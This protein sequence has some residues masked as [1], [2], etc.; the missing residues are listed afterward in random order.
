MNIAQLIS[1]SIQHSLSSFDHL[2]RWRWIVLKFKFA[3]RRLLLAIHDWPIEYRIGNLV[4]ALP[5]SHKLPIDDAATPG[6]SDNLG[7][8]AHWVCSQKGNL[9][10]IDIG[11]NVGD[12]IAVV[13][14]N[15]HFPILA[16]EG[17][18]EFYRFLTMNM[19]TVPDIWTYH[20]L[21]SDTPHSAPGV[22]LPNYGGSKQVAIRADAHDTLRF[23]TLVEVLEEFPQF[24]NSG[25]I[26]IDTDGFDCKILR[27]AL[28][29]LTIARPVVFFEYDPYHL[30]EQG[31]DGISIFEAL[32]GI[33]YEGLLVFEGNG[34][35]M[36]SLELREKVLVEELHCYFLGRQSKKYANLCAFHSNDK[37]LFEYCRSEELR[38]AASIRS[39]DTHHQ[40]GRPV[41]PSDKY[42]FIPS[43]K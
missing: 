39:A 26:K 8:I 11:A 6:R 17:D 22:L 28:P 3:L 20:G 43:R 24:K 35:F 16:I 30:S 33:G 41:F 7:R 13:R 19:E 36:F 37:A 14:K 5:L 18:T 40:N 32:R 38:F 21:L 34:D 25:M 15:S 2:T 27:G 31:D 9:F 10:F 23:H 29:W 1:H 12:T 4:L 42:L